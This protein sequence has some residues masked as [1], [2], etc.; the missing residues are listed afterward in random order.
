[1]IIRFLDR[2]NE[3]A[4]TQSRNIDAVK[5]TRQPWMKV[6]QTGG[7]E[8]V[9]ESITPAKPTQKRFAGLAKNLIKTLCDIVILENLVIEKKEATTSNR[10]LSIQNR[11]NYD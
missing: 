5:A 10:F 3:K 1:M 9:N 6:F 2:K 7:I 8:T 11:S 4:T